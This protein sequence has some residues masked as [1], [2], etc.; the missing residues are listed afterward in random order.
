MA[1]KRQLKKQIK[2]ICGDIAAECIVARYSIPGIDA[3]QMSEI[4]YDVASLQ[5]N[6][7]K[8]ITFGFDKA[9]ADFE[10]K[11]K[12]KVARRKYFAEAYKKLHSD[13]MKGIDGIVKSM[14]KVL[15]AEQKEINKNN[16]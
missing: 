14:N 15:S 9:I 11:R 12:F 16:Q 5:T 7:L 8:R 13:F 4:I 3:E 6:S 1:N 10:N 2:Y